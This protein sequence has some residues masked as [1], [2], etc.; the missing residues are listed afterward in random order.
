M[1]LCELKEEVGINSIVLAATD[2]ALV[3]EAKAGDHAAFAELWERHSKKAFNAAY[4]LMKSRADAE[5]VM[6]DA[7][8]KAYV[9]LCAFDGRAKFSTWLIRIVINSGLMTLR[10]RRS[11]PQSSMEITD[12]EIWKDCEFPDHTKNVEE[13]YA[14]HEGIERLRQAI[15]RLQPTLRN[16]VEIH[17]SSAGS[18][19]E[20]A[21]LAG[22]SVAATKS[23]LL[24]ARIVLRRGLVSEVSGKCCHITPNLLPPIELD[25]SFQG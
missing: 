17:Q 1:K 8:L 11:H 14:K 3:K 15:C 22:I 12:G 25:Q 6:Q 21:E 13:L 24:R 4:R 9:H 16:I 10:R 23:R 2:E 20:I 18:V 7:W 5:D 19:K